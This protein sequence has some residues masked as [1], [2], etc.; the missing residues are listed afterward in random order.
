[1]DAS[2]IVVEGPIGVG[3]TSLASRIADSI[4]A[5]MVYDPERENPFLEAFYNSS[6]NYALHTQLDFLLR[7]LQ[8]QQSFAPERREQPTVSDFLLAK[9]KLFAEQTLN[10]DELWIYN[11]IHDALVS[12][13]TQPNLVIYLQA[14]PETLMDRIQTRGIGFE[15]RMAS[16]YLQRVVD[17]YADFF[18]E[19]SD[20]PLLMVNA[21]DINFV[22]NNRDYENLLEQIESIN[23]GRHFLNPL[24]T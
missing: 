5:K 6:G 15:Q 13:V 18:H 12:K 22:D 23:A 1:M 20:S 7:R 10:E 16:G 14:P 3:K 17:A 8:L 19:Y 2:Y 24:P 11:R 9:D 4:G 21:K